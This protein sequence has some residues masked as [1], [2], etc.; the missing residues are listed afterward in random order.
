MQKELYQVGKL[1]YVYFYKAGPFELVYHFFG[2][3]ITQFK[4]LSS[5]STE[6]MKVMS[7]DFLGG[8]NIYNTNF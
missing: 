8:K 6:G 5:G 4:F 1:S 2:V 7:G 3:V